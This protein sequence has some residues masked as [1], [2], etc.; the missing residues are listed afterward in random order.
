MIRSDF[1][2]LFT[3][4]SLTF[5]VDDQRQLFNTAV[6]DV[7]FDYGIHVDWISGDRFK[8]VIR[9]PKDLAI[10]EPYVNVM[11]ELQRLGAQILQAK[12]NPTGN[13]AIIEAGLQEKPFVHIT[14]K[15]DRSLQRVGGEIALLIR[16]LGD[17]YQD[18]LEDFLRLEQMNFC[19]RPGR[20]QSGKIARA[21]FQYQ[22]QSVVQISLGG[23]NG[24]SGGDFVLTQG[25]PEKEL[26]KKVRQAIAAVPH[27]AALY[28]TESEKINDT[29]RKTVIAE[30]NNAHMAYIESG[31]ETYLDAI[32]EAPYIREQLMRLAEKSTIN[33]RAIGLCRL[34]KVTLKVLQTELPKLRKRGYRLVTVSN[35]K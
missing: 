13:L 25:M 8:K 11:A 17:V 10:V 27:A 16:N 5:D 28:L 1:F 21:V 15:K 7:L 9:V 33:T 14:F 29:F 12:S 31:S 18:I 20:R 34:N 4:S 26:R 2:K 3:R 23:S 30:T 35:F 19:I 6:Y 24:A 22:R 32:Q